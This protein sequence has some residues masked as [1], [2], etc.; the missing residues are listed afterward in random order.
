MKISMGIFCA[1]FKVACNT[2]NRST[3]LAKSNVLFQP[4]KATAKA[5]KDHFIHFI[6]GLQKG[7]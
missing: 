5:N 1:S 3:F 4:I 7:L 2:I 6:N